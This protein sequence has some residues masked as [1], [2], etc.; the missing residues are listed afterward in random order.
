MR[1]KSA[2]MGMILIGIVGCA[3]TGGL[4]EKEKTYGKNP[5]IIGQSFASN[6]LRPGDQWKIYVLASDPDGDMETLT[7]V[8][9]QPGMGS[10]PVSLTKIKGENGKELSGYVYLNT[11]G[12]YGHAFMENQ[13]LTVSI[14]IKDKAGHTSQ[15]VNLSV[16]LVSGHTQKSPPPG[17]FK[18]KEL[19]PIMV[20]LRPVPGRTL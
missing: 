6:Q 7:A 15:P 5:P 17:V 11:T 2:V 1:S 3:H 10:Y 4:E 18:E 13:E 14:Q 19:G 9:D 8:V 16:L 12:Q 20:F